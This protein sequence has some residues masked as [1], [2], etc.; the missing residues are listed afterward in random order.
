M[1]DEKKIN[2]F[3]AFFSYHR[4][5]IVGFLLKTSYRSYLEF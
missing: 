4:E 5:I 2:I 1:E 3:T